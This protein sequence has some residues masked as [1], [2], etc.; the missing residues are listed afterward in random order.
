MKGILY[1]CPKPK[2]NH[3]WYLNSYVDLSQEI[4]GRKRE[5][6][7]CYCG[8]PFKKDDKKLVISHEEW[9]KN[10]KEKI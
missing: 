1:Y 6:G 3:F 7:K 4:L 9:L 10:E 2:C 8:Y 5:S